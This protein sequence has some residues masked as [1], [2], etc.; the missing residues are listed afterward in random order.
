M[1]DQ[2]ARLDAIED[3]LTALEHTTWG[4]KGNNGMVLALREL[5]AEVRIW[6]TD[7]QR[8]RDD[9]AK[10]QRTRSRAIITA[11]VSS[12]IALI[13]VIVTLVVVLTTTGP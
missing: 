9:D 5:T 7:E 12:V 10:D 1:G 13:G 4:V 6:K 8:R 11:A 2:D 3:R